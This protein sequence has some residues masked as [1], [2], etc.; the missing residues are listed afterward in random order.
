MKWVSSTVDTLPEKWCL[1]DVN[2]D[3]VASTVLPK[4]I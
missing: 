4:E 1:K 2:I 3:W